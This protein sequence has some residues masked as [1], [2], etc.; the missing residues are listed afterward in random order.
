VTARKSGAASNNLVVSGVLSQRPG[1]GQAKENQ[2]RTQIAFKH[3][4]FHKSIARTRLPSKPFE[5]L[6]ARG[7]TGP[8]RFR[9]PAN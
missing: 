2:A 7:G 1:S 4:L 3:C 9:N 5:T 6:V 8:H